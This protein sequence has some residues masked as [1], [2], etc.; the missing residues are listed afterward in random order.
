MVVGY[1]SGPWWR[2]DLSNVLLGAAHILVTHQDSTDRDFNM[3]RAGPAVKRTEAQALAIA[4]EVA[5][6]AAQSPE[7]FSQLAQQYSDDPATKARGGRIGAARV[8]QLPVEFV[9]ALG[10]LTI[11]QTSR[12]IQTSLGFHVVKRLRVEPEEVVA[13]LEIQVHHQDSLAFTARDRS[14]GRTRAQAAEI[15]INVERI[16]RNQPD[17]FEQLVAAHSD[18]W[19]RYD[20]GR[21]GD[22]S[23]YEAAEDIPDLLAVDVLAQLKPG[24]VSSV[25][26]DASGFRLFKRTVA[27]HR[28]SAFSPFV[29]GYAEKDRVISDSEITRSRDEAQQ[30]AEEALQHLQRHSEDFDTYR[31]RFCDYGYCEMAPMARPAERYGFK[32]LREALD[33]TPVGAVVATLVETPLG[34]LVARREDERKYVRQRPAQVFELPRPAPIDLATATPDQLLWFGGQYRQRLATTVELPIGSLDRLSGMV[35][36][37]FERI[38]A[39]ESAERAGALASLFD[40]V[41]REFGAKNSSAL[42]RLFDRMSIEVQG[43]TLKDRM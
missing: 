19:S 25:V 10:N 14:R 4:Q 18:A 2:A 40:E 22:S 9:D 30:M 6:R 33:A 27:D 21:L 34:F 11:G 20:G 26:E 36:H 42:R 16:A 41:D 38:A 39:V 17:R 28:K 23:S 43:L 15:A 7:T 3:R 5:K 12:V 1:P 8:M 13:G 32:G 29:I 35:G 31:K 37:A 24:E